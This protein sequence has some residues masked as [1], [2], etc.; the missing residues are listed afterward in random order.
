MSCYEWESGSLKFPSAAWPKFR[1]LMITVWNDRQYEVFEVA[2]KAH[3]AAKAAAKGKRGT[4]RDKPVMAAIARECG[5][6]LNKWGGIADNDCQELW[7]QVQRLILVKTEKST[8]TK[9]P[10]KKD[11]KVFPVSKDCTISYWE[12]FVSFKNETRTLRWSVSENNHARDS[13]HEHWY[14]RRLFGELGRV[15]WTRGTGGKIVG[16]DEYNRDTGHEGGGGN[17]VTRSFGPLG[18]EV[19]YRP[20]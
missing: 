1:K 4:N 14:T 17:Y 3:V 15:V 20:W 2:K 6:S 5:S 7:D 11:L 19:R 12:C 13:A 10:Q 16:N 18:K 8:T 9:N